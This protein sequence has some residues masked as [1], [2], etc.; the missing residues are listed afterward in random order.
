MNGFVAEVQRK[1][2][3]PASI[4][5]NSVPGSRFRARARHRSGHS[6]WVR[7]RVPHAGRTGRYDG[8]RPELA[9]LE[10]RA[11]SPTPGAASRRP[12]F[13]TAGWLKVKTNDANAVGS[14]VAAELQNAPADAQCGDDN[15]FYGENITDRARARSPARTTRRWPPRAT[16]VPWWFRTEF[17]P[18]PA[19]RPERRARR[20]AGSWARPTCGS[21]APRSP[22][23]AVLQGSEPEYDFDITSLIKPG[24]NAIALKLYREQ[25]GRDAQP[26]LQRLDAGRARPEH[27]PQ[28]PGPPARLQHA[29]ALS[30]VARQPGQRRRS[31]EHR[32]DAQGHGQEHVRG[33]PDGRRRRDDHRSQRRQP[34]Q[35]APDGQPRRRARARSSRST[36]STS[37]TRSS[38]GRT[39]W[40]TSRSTSSR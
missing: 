38:G 20:S 37:P 39:R 36:R 7:L 35:R 9:G 21:T 34:D 17:T 31:L 4:E 11:R 32:P 3:V 18:E 27:G 2:A 24:A 33:R 22:P 1:G 25:P 15:I 16:R 8:P 6:R 30:D 26:G 10:Q 19:G 13:D 29:R 23:Q 14:E 40:A 12:G 28:V 5:R